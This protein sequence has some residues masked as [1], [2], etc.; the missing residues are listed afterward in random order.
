MSLCHTRI[1]FVFRTIAFELTMLPQFF[2]SV[3]KQLFQ[4]RKV[5]VPATGSL[6]FHQLERLRCAIGIVWESRGR[7]LLE[8][9]GASVPMETVARSPK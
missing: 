1:G 2:P 8:A 5:S 7:P 9:F 6:M 4:Q 3:G